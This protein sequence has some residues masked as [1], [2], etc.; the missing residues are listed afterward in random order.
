M[1]TKYIELNNFVSYAVSTNSTLGVSKVRG[2]Y[3]RLIESIYGNNY[4]GTDSETKGRSTVT[5]SSVSEFIFALV[6]ITHHARRIAAPSL[7]SLTS[8]WVLHG[9]GWTDLQFSAVR[10]DPISV[11]SDKLRRLDQTGPFLCI[12]TGS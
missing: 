5:F 4:L 7:L 10:V 6:R 2:N 12:Q 3:T 9:A 8:R 1:T 11:V